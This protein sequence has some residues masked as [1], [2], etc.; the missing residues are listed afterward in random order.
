MLRRLTGAL[1]ILALTPSVFAHEGHGHPEHPQG[2]VHYVVNPSHAVPT[3]L[4]CA[5]ALIA[6]IAVR[7]MLRSRSGDGQSR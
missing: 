1:S 3:V 7:R 4:C 6:G 2:I 5:A